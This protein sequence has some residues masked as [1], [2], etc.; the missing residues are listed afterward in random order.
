MVTRRIC[1]LNYNRLKCSI[2]NNKCYEMQK[3]YISIF[4]STLTKLYKCDKHTIKQN[5]NDE[6]ITPT[7]EV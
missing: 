6:N 2:I 4:N 7:W 3:Y 1:V 5:Q